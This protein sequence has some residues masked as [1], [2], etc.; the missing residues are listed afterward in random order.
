MKFILTKELGRLSRWLRILGFDTIYYRGD[1]LGT[2]I[3]QALRDNRTIIT[4][5][6]DI[7]HL[8][9]CTVVVD[10]NKLYA[11]LQEVKDKLSLKI[12][13]EKMFTRCTLCNRE[14]KEVEKEKV[15]KLIPEYVYQH[16]KLFR[17]CSACNKVYWAGSHWGNVS[18]VI[19]KL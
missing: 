3:I 8:Q 13:K 9:K 5:R 18:E 2:L 11:Q 6:K 7:K 14:L 16:Q 4:R 15:K 1:T 10:S 19:A 17:Y 12:D